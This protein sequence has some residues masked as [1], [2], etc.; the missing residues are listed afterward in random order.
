MKLSP[1]SV[2]GAFLISFAAFTASCT[3]AQQTGAGY[4]A[5]AGAAL[6][7]LTG[8][9]TEEVITKAGV[10]AAIGAVIVAM[11]EENTTSQQSQ[12]SAPQ[13]APTYPYGQST[14]TPGYIKSPYSPY[15]TIDVRGIAPGT[16]VTE[17]GSTNIF[18][19]P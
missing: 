3:P 2:A 16:K 4:G 13:Q 14:G 1:Y 5:L 9:N 17:P 7:T 18:I 6:G 19:V 12:Q 8:D 15:N 10:G 11:Q